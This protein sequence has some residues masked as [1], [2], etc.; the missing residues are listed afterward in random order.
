MR[1]ESEVAWGPGLAVQS[2]VLTVRRGGPAG[3]LRDARTITLGVGGDRRPL[4]LYCSASGRTL[5]D[6]NA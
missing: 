5:L 1:V 6:V 2:V 4:P 3:A